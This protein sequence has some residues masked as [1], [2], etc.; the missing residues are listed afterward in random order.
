MKVK[1]RK[2]QIKLNIQKK[3]LL[4]IEKLINQKIIALKVISIFLFMIGRR[5]KIKRNV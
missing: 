1:K 2:E 3:V 5:R 4:E